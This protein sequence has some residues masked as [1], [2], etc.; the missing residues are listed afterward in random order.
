[1]WVS[2]I[3]A[4]ALALAGGG[5]ETAIVIAVIVLLANGI[6]QEVVEPIAFGSTLSLNPL[7]VLVAH[8]AS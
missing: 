8:R 7:V 2:G 1:V 6:L 5:T 4:V 3:Y